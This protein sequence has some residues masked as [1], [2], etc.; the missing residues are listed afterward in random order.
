LV[1]G[2]AERLRADASRQ[3]IDGTAGGYK[4]RLRTKAESLTEPEDAGFGESRRLDA[5]GKPEEVA[6]VK[7]EGQTEG[8]TGR[9]M[10]DASWRLTGRCS[11]RT[12]VPMRSRRLG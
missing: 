1:A 10:A 9:S 6:P 7:A 3:E 4:L 5:K 2:T 8:T 11:Q 12:R